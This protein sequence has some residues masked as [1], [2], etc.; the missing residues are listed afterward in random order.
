VLTGISTDAQGRRTINVRIQDTGTGL[1][2]VVV[3]TAINI[4]VNIPAFPVGTTTAQQVVGTRID[5][6]KAATMQIQVFDIA[7]NSSS[8]DPL[9]VEQRIGDDGAAVT[10]TYDGIPSIEHY[11][12]LINDTPGLT[13]LSGT[14]AEAP[15]ALDALQDGEER[16]LDIAPLMP[17]DRPSSIT[18]TAEGAPGSSALILVGDMPLDGTTVRMAPAPAPTEAGLAAASTTASPSVLVGPEVLAGMPAGVGLDVAYEPAPMLYKY[19]E[20]GDRAFG[21]VNPLGLPVR[22]R[23]SAEEA[24]TGLAY[25]LDP[26]LAAAEVTLSLPVRSYDA[27]LGEFAWLIEVR[28]DTGQFVGYRRLTATFDPNTN[29][30]QANVQLGEMDDRLLLPVALAPAQVLL[31]DPAAHLWSDARADAADFGEL[32]ETVTAMDVLGP[33]VGDRVYVY[34][35]TWQAS[36]WVDVNSVTTPAQ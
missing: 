20:L 12:V 28:D 14:V 27:A 35:P 33:R 34:D 6:T 21:H 15:F 29:T 1:Q 8:C 26:A 30:L 2:R 25:Q 10:Q 4:Q 13:R 18:L 3:T 19:G 24:S 5:Q 16:T 32:G 31:A 11:L 22:L 9:V 23:V 7:N 17:T 36:G